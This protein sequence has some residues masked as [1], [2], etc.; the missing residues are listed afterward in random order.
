M[1]NKEEIWGS[2][3][4]ARGNE[5]NRGQVRCIRTVDLRSHSMAGLSSSGGASIRK[6]KGSYGKKRV[7]AISIR[8][9]LLL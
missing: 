6:E 1:M 4:L 7:L 8:G 2:F 5:I 9:G 3:G